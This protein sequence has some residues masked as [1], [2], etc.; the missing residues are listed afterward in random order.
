VKRTEKSSHLC[1]V[2]IFPCLSIILSYQLLLFSHDCDNIGES[3]NT[4]YG[5]LAFLLPAPCLRIRVHQ[6]IPRH[7]QRSSPS[8][9]HQFPLAQEVCDDCGSIQLP[10]CCHRW[11]CGCHGNHPPPPDR[12]YYRWINWIWYRCHLGTPPLIYHLESRH[13]VYRY[14]CFEFSYSDWFYIRY[15]DCHVVSRRWHASL[16]QNIRDIGV[17]FYLTY[18]LIRSCIRWYVGYTPYHQG[19]EYIRSSW[20]IF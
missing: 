6:L 9:L 2:Y 8:Y 16:V 3:P 17:T 18:Y 14:A 4:L 15:L 13:L 19:Y 12:E 10:R 5:I 11:D 20:K 7:S 1:G